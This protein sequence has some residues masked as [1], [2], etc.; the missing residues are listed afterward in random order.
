MIAS[1][2]EWLQVRL[3]GKGSRFF[4]NVSVVARSL[5]FW[6]VYGNRLIPLL[7]GTLT[8]MVNKWVYIVQWHCAIKKIPYVPCT[9]PPSPQILYTTTVRHAAPVA[10]N[11]LSNV[12]AARLLPW[13]D[14]RTLA[15]YNQPV[16]SDA[17]LA[18]DVG[19]PKNMVTLITWGMCI[20]FS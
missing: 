19:M 7:H 13:A 2:A 6:P 16:P 15:A 12:V 1:L 9:P 8:H 3:P 20:T 11:V 10:L 17:A 18:A 4:E 14:G 5:E